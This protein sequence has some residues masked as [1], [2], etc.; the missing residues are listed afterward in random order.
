MNTRH[1]IVPSVVGRCL[2]AG[3]LSA[4]ALWSLTASAQDDLAAR[5]SAQEKATLEYK[6]ILLEAARSGTHEQLDS[7]QARS[8]VSRIA[9][10]KQLLQEV[11]YGLE[12]FHQLQSICTNASSTASSLMMLGVVPRVPEGVS[13]NEHWQS[14]ARQV[15]QNMGHHES[16]MAQL[17]PFMLRCMTPM[18]E[19]AGQK[20]M[21]LTPEEMTPIRHAG[22]KQARDGLTTTY[23]GSLQI[24]DE[25]AELPAL[26]GALISALVDS[27]PDFAMLLRVDQRAPIAAR[28][29]LSAGRLDQE[30][31]KEL[32][33]VAAAFDSTQCEALCTY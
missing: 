9:D 11:Q 20:I 14:V 25:S 30:Q 5:A 26:R 10:E 24:I 3:L 2:L 29:R 13:Q 8:L 19:L 1:S 31:R 33:K 4:S 7:P 12:D 6:L 22:L 17:L 16:E 23:A 32:E 15:A 28:V 18:V 21:A 27:A